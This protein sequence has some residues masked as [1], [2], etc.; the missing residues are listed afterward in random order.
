MRL[1]LAPRH[2]QLLR[3]AALGVIVVSLTYTTGRVGTRVD[4]TAE[5]LSRLTSGTEQLI[6][7]IDAKRPVTVHAFVSDTVPTEYV[8]TRTRLLNILHEMEVAGGAGLRV[9]IVRPTAGSKTADEAIDNFGI[10]PRTVTNRAGGQIGQMDVFL[11]LAF[12]SG[13]REEVVPFMDRGLSVEY[14]I[15]RALRVVLQEKKKV[16]GIV[17][18]DVNLM[19]G[20]D[21]RTMRPR[22]PWRIVTEL[23]KQYTVRA[24]QPTKAIPADVDVL[25]VPQLSSF[26]EPELKTIRDYVDAG[27]PAL[28][29]VDPL[30]GFNVEL[31]P[32]LPKPA[33]GGQF[34]RQRPSAPKGD[35]AG[36][37]RHLGVDWSPT[38]IVYDTYQPHRMFEKLPEHFIFVTERPDGTK[39]FA[40]ADPVVNGLSEVALLYAGALTPTAAGKARFSPLLTTGA[41]SGTNEWKE[42]FRRHPLFG[43]QQ[44]E[45]KRRTSTSGTRHV[46]AARIR[47][48]GDVEAE[49]GAKEKDEKGKEAARKTAA[50]NVIVL[51]DLDLFGDPL[52]A[53][54]ERGGDVDGDGID[55][56][57]FDNVPFL[58]NAVDSLAGD[59]RFISLRKRR[60]RFRRLTKVDQLTVDAQKRR[61]KAIDEANGKAAEELEQAQKELD[62][63]VKEIERRAGLDEATKRVMI[64]SERTKQQRRLEARQKRIEADKKRAIRDSE[65]EHKRAVGKVQDR[66]RLIAVL[67]PP[68]PALLLGTFILFRKRRRERDSI[69]QSRRK[70]A[71]G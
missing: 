40:V 37:L 17:S 13:P 19:G 58:L 59:D 56:I 32:T 53:L 48:A 63:S 69:P 43:L 49:A 1:A 44:V 29:A 61:D 18:G 2:H 67:L 24:I 8:A 60:P 16:L 11:G 9:R 27:R 66:I 30:P 6:R 52:F 20:F 47:S 71:A 26:T 12:V 22:K 54:H 14:E 23:R 25:F 21:S 68:I 3:F 50:F 70:G 57:R 5:G 33:G 42:M 46:L 62:Q 51:A 7:S 38:T 15:A 28:I 35:H 10:K 45:P 39:P 41:S 64:E 31:S 34:G 36:F 4:V 65:R 55:D